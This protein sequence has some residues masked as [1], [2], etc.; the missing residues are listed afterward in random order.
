ME[1]IRIK[2]H[3]VLFRE[4]AKLFKMFGRAGRMEEGGSEV[5]AVG[6]VYLEARRI[7]HRRRLFRTRCFGRQGEIGDEL[8]APPEVAGDGRMPKLGLRSFEG[9]FC[10]LEKGDGTMHVKPAFTALCDGKILQDLGAAPSPFAF[11]MRSSFASL[12]DP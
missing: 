5:L 4:G 10:M 11:L 7:Q 12:P 6:D 2:T 8:A 1:P 9:R 3:S